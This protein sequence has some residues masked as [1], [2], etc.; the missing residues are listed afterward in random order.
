MKCAFLVLLSELGI[1]AFV[2]LVGLPAFQVIFSNC[3]HV[4]SNLYSQAST[5]EFA[6]SGF[7]RL[8]V[9]P[10]SCRPVPSNFYLQASTFTFAI[11]ALQSELC[12]LPHSCAWSGS[13]FNVLPSNLYRFYLQVCLRS[14]AVRIQAWRI[15]ALGRAPDI[16]SSTVNQPAS[17]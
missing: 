17:L 2:R 3:K 10:S 5:S 4:A 14:I 11:S 6:L 1:G 12:L 8:K 13:T 15:R 9:L 7:L 16:Q